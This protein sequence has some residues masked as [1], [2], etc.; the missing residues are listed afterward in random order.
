MKMYTVAAQDDAMVFGLGV[1]FL[2]LNANTGILPH[3]MNCS[4]G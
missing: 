4:L 1:S 2:E 3:V